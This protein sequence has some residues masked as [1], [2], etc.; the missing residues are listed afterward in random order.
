MLKNLIKLLLTTGDG[1]INLGDT[2]ST[3]LATAS[4][5]AFKNANTQNGITITS[6]TYAPS[7][8]TFNV[9]LDTSD[10]D[11][12]G[13]ASGDYMD[14]TIGAVSDLVTAGVIGYANA[15]FST[16]K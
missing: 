16:T 12:S 14:G 10:A 8:G 2:F 13:M 5:Y 15:S 3:E 7:T 4:L 1:A 6:V 11:Y 9:Q